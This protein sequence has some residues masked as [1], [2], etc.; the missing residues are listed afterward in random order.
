MTDE[1]YISD[2]Q[3]SVLLKLARK[4]IADKLGIDVKQDEWAEIVKL[5]VDPAF[6]EKQGTFVT[7]TMNN[8]LRG[9][10][11]SLT[12]T[13][14]IKES[15]KRNAINAAFHDSR[16]T[17]LTVDEFD[18]LHVEVSILT[19]PKNLEYIDSAD[20]LQKIRPQV[21][22]VVVRKGGASAT[23]LPQVW[24][25]LP[26]PKDFLVHLC[27]KAGLPSDIWET[28]HPDVLI[29]QVQKFKEK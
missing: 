26:S 7:L 4:I 19:E 2:G 12:A 22:G 28:G 13:E 17:P 27:M 15:V 11:G 29:Y 14:S 10:I 6:E 18:D 9:C 1:K 5:L 25:Q 21:D 24:Q 16:F 8:D 20:L 3:G 23:F